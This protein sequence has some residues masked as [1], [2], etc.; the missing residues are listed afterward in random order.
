MYVAGSE[1]V[2]M[3][4]G[5]NRE[6]AISSARV[7]D[8]QSKCQLPAGRADFRQGSRGPIKTG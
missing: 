7:F 5:S 4:A 3:Q 6:A 1:S 8:A 2:V